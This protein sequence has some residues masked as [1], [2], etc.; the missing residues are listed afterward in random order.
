MLTVQ[1]Y[2]D[3]PEELALHVQANVSGLPT[4]HMVLKDAHELGFFFGLLRSAYPDAAIEVPNEPVLELEVS[5]EELADFPRMLAVRNT[6]LAGGGRAT[7]SAIL[8]GASIVGAFVEFEL[9]QGE[10]QRLREEAASAASLAASGD[11]PSPMAAPDRPFTESELADLAA[12]DGVPSTLPPAA[13]VTEAPTELTWE[14][15]GESLDPGGSVTLTM[16]APEWMQF[17]TLELDP[18]EA[19]SVS[20]LTIAAFPLDDLPDRIQKGERITF[21][22]TNTTGVRVEMVA[23]I[24]GDPVEESDRE[25]APRE[26]PTNPGE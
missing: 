7:R 6:I 25:L 9:R 3:K 12:R 23:T 14:F 24:T 16:Y 19:F 5:E 26:A 21:R 4:R 15:L 2:D 18:A 20:E 11:L 22:V 8:A 17:P 10:E 13:S 1:M